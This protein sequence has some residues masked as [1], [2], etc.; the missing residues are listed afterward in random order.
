MAGWPAGWTVAAREGRHA[1]TFH[2]EWRR[3]SAM[4]RGSVCRLSSDPRLVGSAPSTTNTANPAGVVCRRHVGGTGSSFIFFCDPQLCKL[5]SA[6]TCT[7]RA[8]YTERRTRREERTEKQDK[9]R[10][11]NLSHSLSSPCIQLFNKIIFNK[12]LK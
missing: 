3:S 5:H 12:R 9:E 2:S 1:L 8:R 4:A 10:S 7:T 11:S 6:L